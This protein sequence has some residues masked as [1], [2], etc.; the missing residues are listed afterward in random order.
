[1]VMAKVKGEVQQDDKTMIM[2]RT[3]QI[4]AGLPNGSK[5][6]EILTNSFIGKLWDSLDHP[7]LLYMGDEFK[8]RRP[9]GAYNVRCIS[10][11]RII[12]QANSRRTH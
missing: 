6:Q 4:V 8:Y 2:E 10:D 7:P 12:S 11:Q 9:D 3:I 5:T 1:M